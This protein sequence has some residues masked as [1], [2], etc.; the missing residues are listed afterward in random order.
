MLLLA[1][2]LTLCSAG[3][4]LLPVYQTGFRSAVGDGQHLASYGFDLSKLTVQPEEIIPT[5]KAKDEVR[6]V[7]ESLVETLTVPEVVLK[8]QNEHRHERDRFLVGS[9]RVIGVEIGG[10]SRAYPIHI[11]NL[12]EIVNDRVG[13]RLI[14]VTWSALSGSAVVFARKTGQEFGVSGLVYQSNL[15]MF[16]RQADVHRES[17]W[18]QLG[19]RAIS[20]PAS[21]EALEVLPFEVTTWAVWTAEHPGTRVFEGLRTLDQSYSEAQEPF[22][23]YLANDAIRFPVRPLW[24]HGAPAMKTRVM[25]SSVEGKRWTVV[26]ES[27]EAGGAATTQPGERRVYAFLFAWYAQHS[28]D[29]D[30]RALER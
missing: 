24:P 23:M 8:N 10:E 21:G 26:R 7:P 29:S 9:D 30:Y 14:A 27:D 11:L 1:A 2:A 12:H 5:G 3:I 16:D 13:G 18:S 6:A 28:G 19:M 22:D 15:L 20:G 17:L 25:A 4:V